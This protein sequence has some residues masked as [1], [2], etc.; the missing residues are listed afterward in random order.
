MIRINIVL[1]DHFDHFD[2][3]SFGKF[4]IS[5]RGYWIYFN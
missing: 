2:R 3:Q 1:L 4:M 5:Y